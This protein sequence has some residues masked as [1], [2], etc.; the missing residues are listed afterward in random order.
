M[1]ATLVPYLKIWRVDYD[2]DN[3]PFREVPLQIPNFVDPNDGISSILQ[4]GRLPGAGIKSFSWSLDGVQ[5]AEV[6][7]NI[8]AT[9]DMYFQSVS[10]FFNGQTQAGQSDKASFLDLVI[11]SPSKKG[12]NAEEGQDPTKETPNPVCTEKTAQMKSQQYE[13]SSYRIKVTAGWAP[14]GQSSD[15]VP[16]ALLSAIRKSRI[17]LYLQQTRHDFQFNQDGSLVLSIDYQAALSGMTTSP[18]ADILGQTGPDHQ[19]KIESKQDEIDDLKEKT[20]EADTE[21]NRTAHKDALEELKKL[22]QQDR[23]L[24]YKRF[25][26]KMFATDKVYHLAFDPAELSLPPYSELTPEGRAKRAK[27]RQSSAPHAESGQSTNNVL[28]EAVSTAATTGGTAEDAATTSNVAMQNQYKA[29]EES[30][31]MIFVSYFYLGDLLDTV[32]EQVRQNSGADTLPYSFFLS[33]VEMVDPLVA[34]QIRDLENIIKCGQDLREAKFLKTLVD[35]DPTT[36]S[37]EAGVYQ[38]MNIGDI[39]ISVDAFQVWFKDYVVK[40]DRDKYYFLHFVKDLAAEL[41]TKALSSKCFGEGVKFTQRF[42]VQPISYDASEGKDRLKPNATVRAGNPNLDSGAVYSLAKSV[43]AYNESTPAKDAGLGLVL[44]GT[45]SKPKGLYGENSYETD[46]AQGIYHNYLGASCGLVKTINFNRFDQPYLRESKIQKEG[47]FSAAQLRELYSAEIELYGNTLYRNGNYIYLNPAFVGAGDNLDLLNILGLHGYYLITGVNSVVTENSFKVS[48]SALH[49]A[50]AFPESKLMVSADV[51][52]AGQQ[53]W[54]GISPE[55]NPE[56]SSPPADPAPPAPTAAPA[57][58]EERAETE[59][60]EVQSGGPTGAGR[61]EV[62]RG[63]PVGRTGLTA[64]TSVS[65][66]GARRRD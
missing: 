64:G 14:R 41:I 57:P 65:G 52:K 1:Q 59:D 53:E 40:K 7:N 60:V 5:P 66:T 19:A 56:R 4:K 24:K 61:V 2:K 26:E 28:L 35:A 51:I 16:A 27:R 25:L 34:L 12:S 38:L 50:V 13:G 49:Q 31:K 3:K 11:A 32:L 8:S 33:E 45:D 54:A 48:V 39:P 43:R 46:I 55:E 47:S 63:A 36:F 6:D 23:L 20:Q 58:V 37:E 9:L 44:L 42:D 18:S 15:Q 10:D 62:T 30:G 17:T 22:R 29:L 21:A